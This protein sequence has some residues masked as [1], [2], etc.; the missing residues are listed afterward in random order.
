MQS[1]K[2]CTPTAT[3]EIFLFY[4]LAAMATIG[5]FAKPEFWNFA[6]VQGH[7]SIKLSIQMSGILLQTVSALMLALRIFR[8]PDIEQRKNDHERLSIA[9]SENF[10]KNLK[11]KTKEA[12]LEIIEHP[13]VKS[14][15]NNFY[16]LAFNFGNT[17]RQVAI[18]GL[19]LFAVGALL[20]L[21]SAG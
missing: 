5:A 1:N 9:L 11:S 19:L 18:A 7:D 16:S 12:R 4:V 14:E 8:G 17:E 3:Q 13:E 21:A 6:G 15:I 10:K 2:Y 20:Q